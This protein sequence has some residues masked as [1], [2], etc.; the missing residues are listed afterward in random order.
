MPLAGT[1]EAMFPRDNQSLIR[2]RVQQIKE[3]PPLPFIAQK[4]LNTNEENADI[5]LLAGLIEQDPNLSA[6]ILGLANSAYFGWSGR[7]RTIYDAIYKVLG[8]KTVK[9]LALGL[10]LGQ[11]LHSTECPGFRCEEYWFIAMATATMLQELGNHVE[12]RERIDIGNV[13]I[14]GLLHNLGLPVMVHT[15]PHEMSEILCLPESRELSLSALMQGRLGMNHHQ[16]GGWLARKWHLPDDIVCVIENHFD[17]SYR[18]R[19]WPVVLLSGFCSRFAKTLFLRREPPKEEHL[20]SLLGIPLS[21][22]E[23]LYLSLDGR[24]DELNDTAAIMARGS[25]A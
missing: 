1:E 20:L 17:E 9:S 24:W 11:S 2:Q 18:G 5:S 15:F 16:A 22:V 7:V 25:A 21:R 14:D 3:L 19:Y 12:T 13:Y 10:A 23:R 6:R 4:I 8:L